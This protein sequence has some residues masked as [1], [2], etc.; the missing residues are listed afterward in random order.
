MRLADKSNLRFSEDE[1]RRRVGRLRQALEERGIEIY[2]GTMPEHLNYFTGFDPTGVMYYQQVFFRPTMDRPILLTHKAES[3]LAR[4]TCWIDDIRIWR[5]GE[6][7]FLQSCEILQELDV[8]PNATMGLELDNWYLKPSTYARLCDSWPAAR[9]VDV[10]DV[11]MELRLRM[12]SA[13][14]EYM[15]RAAR[16]ADVGVT[17]AMETLQPG[18]RENEVDAAIESAMITAGSEYPAFPNPLLAS[19]P[20]TG[21]FH[22]LPGERVVGDG[23][24]VTME[25]TGV[26]ARYNSNIVRTAVA[27]RP[28]SKVRQ[29][30]DIVM[31][32][33]WRA[34]DVVAPGVPAGEID[35]VAKEARAGYEKFFPARSGFAVGL[36]YPPSWMGAMDILEGDPHVLEPGMIFSLEPSIAQYDDLTVVF[37]NNVLV[38]EN[39]SEVLHTSPAGLLELA[40]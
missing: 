38:T 19:G 14:V 27:G 2:V 36:G 37:G 18:R 35:R 6:D 23:D 28:N 4:V 11:G 20:R 29:L 34:L 8:R 33:F 9:I 32:A 21:L 26:V 39:G 30:H 5:H 12:S 22:A 40:A 1:F 10:T 3:E 7:P 31:D 15:R 25:I 13:E 24:P 17:A 16:L